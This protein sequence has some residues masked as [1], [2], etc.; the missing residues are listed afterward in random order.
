MVIVDNKRSKHK[1]FFIDGVRITAFSKDSLWEQ[2][3][4]KIQLGQSAVVVAINP[5]KIMQASRDKNLMLYLSSFDFP[6]A[7]GVGIVLVSKLK[8]G[9]IRYR[10]TGTDIMEDMVSRSNKIDAPLFL[11]GAKP[12][13]AKLAAEKLEKKYPGIRIVGTLD[14]YQSDPSTVVNAIKASGAKIVF[15][16]LGSPRQEYFMYQNREALE[17]CILQGVGGSFDVISETKIRAPLFF[18]KLGLEWLYRLICEPWRLTRQWD[19]L[20]F[21]FLTV[22]RPLK[23]AKLLYEK[24]DSL[25]PMVSYSLHGAAANF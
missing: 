22:V 5:E 14:G 23:K 10:L 7:D 3:Y 9:C 1:D 20:R 25:F 17:G 12:G 4:E 18:R 13:I 11:Y 8:G 2:V 21:L 6:I 24:T 16:A 15:V 19:I